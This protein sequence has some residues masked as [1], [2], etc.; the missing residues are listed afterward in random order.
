[1]NILENKCKVAWMCIEVQSVYVCM[2]V[3]VC[4][5]EIVCSWANPIITILNGVGSGHIS[6]KAMFYMILLIGGV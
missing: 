4:E 5:R 2:Y 1:M 6:D 3:C